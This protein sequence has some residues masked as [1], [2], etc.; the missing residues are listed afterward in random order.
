MYLFALDKILGKSP[1]GGI[2]LITPENKTYTEAMSGYYPATYGF[3]N[4]EEG[5]FPSGWIDNS[6][7]PACTVEVIDQYD[8]HNKVMRLYDPNDERARAKMYFNLP[9]NG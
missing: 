3:E 4:D 9:Q 1:I 6:T 5:N 7:D 8:G 2:N